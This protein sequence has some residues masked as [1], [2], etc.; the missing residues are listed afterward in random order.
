MKNYDPAQ[1]II[2]FGNICLTA[3]FAPDTFATFEPA[4]KLVTTTVGAAGEVVRSFS[5]NKTGTLTVRI[6]QSSVINDLLSAVAA[7]DQLTKTGVR[8]LQVKDLNGTTVH[9]AADA[10]I[11]DRPH[12]ERAAVAGQN[13]W[14][15]AGAKWVEHHGGSNP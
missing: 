9:T 13:E 2:T 11:E 8:P 5:R 4:D 7:E 1:Y 6:L 3:G 12:E 15:L 10:W 14:V